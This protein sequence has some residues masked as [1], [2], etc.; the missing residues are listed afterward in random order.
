MLLTFN[1]MNKKGTILF[2]VYGFPRISET[3]I[4]NQ[5]ALLIDQGCDVL[6]YG[7][8]YIS[9]QE[10]TL[11]GF[12]SYE[13]PKRFFTY[14]N[15]VQHISHKHFFIIS[16]L[17]F[18][19]FQKR[20]HLIAYFKTALSNRQLYIKELLIARY[21]IEQKVDVIHAHFG[22]YGMEAA[23]VK[24]IGLDIKLVTTFHGYDLRIGMEDP[25][26]YDLLKK[27]EVELIAI[28]SFNRMQ[29]LKMGFK[30]EVITTI[31]NSIDTTFYS[32]K[33]RELNSSTIKLITVAR[34][35][36]EKSLETAI[37]AMA[38]LVD[39][40]PDMELSY[41]I[42]GEGDQR[43]YL[44]H[45][46]KELNLEKYVYLLGAKNSNEVRDAL[47]EA[48][49][50]LLT[51]VK[52]AFPTVLLEAQSIGL[53]VISTDVGGVSEIAVNGTLIPIGDVAA[54]EIALLNLIDDPLFLQ[55]VGENNRRHIVT[56]FDHSV[57]LQQLLKCYFE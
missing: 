53:A 41:H 47:R 29:L 17:F 32:P 11:K 35:V 15:L 33:K 54:L 2:W 7:H 14:K 6:I 9:H 19:G 36:E 56:H 50:F 30:E 42:I 16:T 23:V 21:C 18:M 40:R 55:Q 49:I 45:L 43:V 52:E 3:F 13:F 28:S 39:I 24:Q 22:P 57:I 10:E 20:F 37:K 38:R 46:I 48:S 12:E 51:S 4:R 34:L 31:H 5:M 27:C 26:Y 44:D 25:S 1:M 8:K